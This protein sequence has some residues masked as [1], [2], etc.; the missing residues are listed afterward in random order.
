LPLEARCRLHLQVLFE[1]SRTGI[2]IR[3]T[4]SRDLDHTLR[5]IATKFIHEPDGAL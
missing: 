2:L 4:N 1:L 3:K 5:E